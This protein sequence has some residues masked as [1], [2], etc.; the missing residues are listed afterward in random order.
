[1]RE[2]IYIMDI[3]EILIN[4]KVLAELQVNQKL[5]T[6]DQYLN[7]EY[8]S[9]IPEFLRR[10]KRQDNRNEAIKK[11]N[12]VV[13]SAIEHIEKE[14]IKNNNTTL[15]PNLLQQDG[16]NEHQSN[17]VEK[18]KTGYDIKIYLENSL[19]GLKSLKETYGTCSQT[20]AR[21][22]VIINKVEEVLK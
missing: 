7:I 3:D 1:L 6:R 22:D 19:C 10:W 2:L 5:I 9:I 8:V 20:C 21:L 18:R 15:M 17:L 14:K 12:L 13:H 4:L 11:I 16:N